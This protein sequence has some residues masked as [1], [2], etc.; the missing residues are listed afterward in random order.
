MSFTNSLVCPECGK[1]YPLKKQLIQCPVCEIDL[2][3][4]TQSPN[5]NK[6]KARDISN[7]SGPVI[8]GDG[9]TV[10][11]QAKSNMANYEFSAQR[12]INQF[13]LGAPVASWLTFSAALMW[14]LH[15]SG[16]I[17]SVLSIFGVQIKSDPSKSDLLKQIINF[18][19]S[20][21][22][23]YRLVISG[24]ITLV[25]LYFIVV[26]IN[27]L[28]DLNNGIPIHVSGKKFYK[29]YRG[30]VLEGSFNSECPAEGCSGSLTVTIA[31]SNQEGCKIIGK[32]N[33]R[34]KLHTYDFDPE[35]LKGGWV[36]LTEKPKP[37]NSQTH[38]Q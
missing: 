38:R 36:K 13:Q 8:L 21:I 7:N 11:E 30:T 20:T 17:A 14:F 1:N 22:Y 35:T 26:W 16:S 18:F 37:N 34:P 33:K 29:K 24:N 6:R 5:V 4:P 9:A 23:D 3:T 12:K 2:V 25:S 31:P 32:C 15:T 28:R 19:A 10:Y 27:K